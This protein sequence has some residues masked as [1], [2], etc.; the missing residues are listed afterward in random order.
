MISCVLRGVIM[1]PIDPMPQVAPIPDFQCGTE[2][3]PQQRLN[4]L[5]TLLMTFQDAVKNRNGREVTTLKGKIEAEL[6]KTDE[7]CNIRIAKN[8]EI[9]SNAWRGLSLVYSQTEALRTYQNISIEELSSDDEDLPPGAYISGPSEIPCES[10]GESQ[11]SSEELSGYD[12]AIGP[13][14]SLKK[15]TIGR[16]EF[17]LPNEAEIRGEMREKF[18]KVKKDQ[19]GLFQNAILHEYK[20][21]VKKNPEDKQILKAKKNIALQELRNIVRQKS[22]RSTFRL[23]NG[24][25]FEDLDRVSM[26]REITWK[27]LANFPIQKED[28]QGVSFNEA[29]QEILEMLQ[30]DSEINSFLREIETEKFQR[31]AQEVLGKEVYAFILDQIGDLEVEEYASAHEESPISTPLFVSLSG[32]M[33]PVKQRRNI[34]LSSSE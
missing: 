28:F 17:K 18:S 14:S 19:A 29:E 7:Y 5:H 10:L 23:L 21:E 9:F 6:E 15:D 4:N 26:L 16:R 24:C 30:E 25:N 3:R 12:K 8:K 1:S 27:A 31:K 13:L 34:S 2:Y 33:S 20:E 22:K 11:E 32:S